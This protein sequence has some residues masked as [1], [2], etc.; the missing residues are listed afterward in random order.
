MKT[1]KNCNKG[2]KR[3]F[4]FFFSN[5]RFLFDHAKHG[6]CVCFSLCVCVCAIVYLSSVDMSILSFGSFSFFL[7]RSLSY[8][9]DFGF[10]D[11]L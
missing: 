2:I 6:V 7:M 4:L 8:V 1:K 10:G 3:N 5:F 11:T 9:V